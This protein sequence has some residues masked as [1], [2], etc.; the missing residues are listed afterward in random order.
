MASSN[1]T[2]ALFNASDDTLDLLAAR[3]ATI[4]CHCVRSCIREFRDGTHD[5]KAFMR[6]HDPRVVV[7]DVSV[8][9]YMN[10]TFLQ[11]VRDTHLLDG[12]GLILTTTNVRRLN[13]IAGVTTG[14]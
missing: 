10:W 6:D 8:P 1:R 4:R 7:W 13:D 2:V 14:A 9:Y 11:N 12:R 3:L 5:L